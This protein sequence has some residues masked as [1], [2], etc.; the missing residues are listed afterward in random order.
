[1]DILILKLLMRHWLKEGKRKRDHSF[2]QGHI[3]LEV[4]SIL[5]FGVE[6]VKAHGNISILDWELYCK[7]AL[8]E[9]VLLGLMF[10]GSSKTLKMKNWQLDGISL[11]LSCLCSELMHIMTVREENHGCIQRKHLEL[12]EIRYI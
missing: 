11:V 2:C 10:Q 5:L 1:M 3:M 4:R 7:L 8:V 9:L 6:T 12:L